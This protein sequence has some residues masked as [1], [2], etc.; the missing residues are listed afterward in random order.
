MASI[1]FISSFLPVKVSKKNKQT[2]KNMTFIAV[3][4]IYLNPEK[5]RKKHQNDFKNVPLQLPLKINSVVRLRPHSL[6]P[7]TLSSV[8][9]RQI[10]LYCM[11]FVDISVN[12]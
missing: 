3:S 6:R 7:I 2:Q 8:T 1:P 5:M 11:F 12:S 10:N 9:R 4:Q